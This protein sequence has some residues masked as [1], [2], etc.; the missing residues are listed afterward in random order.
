MMGQ[1]QPAPTGETAE[2]W[3]AWGKLKSAIAQ[4]DDAVVKLEA[5]RAYALGRPNLAPEYR[6]KMAEVQAMRDRAVWLRDT[7]RSVMKTFGVELSGLSGLGIAPA[8]VWPAVV[9]GVAW[10]GGKALDLWQFAKKVDEQ[11]RLESQGVAPQQAA[12]IVER[13]AAAGAGLLELLARNAAWI[14][15]GVGALV[16]LPRLLG[17]RGRG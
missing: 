8:L 15:L 13:Q 17:G 5:S 11:R 4:L 14:A 12:A 6:A 2:W 10:I 9:A 3:N 16:I 1:T 7:I